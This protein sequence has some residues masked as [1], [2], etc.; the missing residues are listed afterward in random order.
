[1]DANIGPRALAR[2]PI[3]LK[4]PATAP[5]S[6]SCTTEMRDVRVGTTVADAKK[7]RTIQYANIR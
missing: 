5:L 6:V 1:M 2:A 3:D 4:T 7:K